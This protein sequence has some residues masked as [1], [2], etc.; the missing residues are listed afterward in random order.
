MAAIE[1][2][3]P[4]A[5]LQLG[6]TTKP[7]IVTDEEM[8]TS[9]TGLVPVS[10]PS[11]TAPLAVGKSP[12]PPVQTTAVS[13]TP[14]VQPPR[15]APYCRRKPRQREDFRSN[16]YQQDLLQTPRKGGPN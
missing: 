10:I 2:V 5:G 6:I 9:G 4:A 3:A 13:A 15:S 7:E 8:I 12:A 11:A 14:S 16:C 1:S